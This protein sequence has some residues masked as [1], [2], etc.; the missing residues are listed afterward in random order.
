MNTIEV[1]SNKFNSTLKQLREKYRVEIK[2]QN[3]EGIFN[4]KRLKFSEIIK[5][6]LAI[7]SSIIVIFF[8]MNRQFLKK[9]LNT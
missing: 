2:K 7:S 4:S 3:N 6:E 9:T 8:K 1:E 5:E